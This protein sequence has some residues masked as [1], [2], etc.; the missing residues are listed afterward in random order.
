MTR[1]DKSVCVVGAG[2]VG[3]CCAIFLQRAGLQVTLIDRG[4]PGRACSYGNAGIL[5][6]TERG[7]IGLPGMF[8]SLPKWILDP[9]HPFSVRARHLPRMIPWGLAL[10][11]ASRAA[12]VERIADWMDVFFASSVERYGALL[13]S[14]GAG[15]LVRQNGYLCVYRDRRS[16]DRDAYFWDLHRRRAIRL[17]ELGG[18]E[19]RQIAPS[20]GRGFEYGLY[21]PDEGRVLD[22]YGVSRAIFDA[23]VADG[24][25]FLT[26]E[27]NQVDPSGA[28]A[29]VV[30]AGGRRSFDAVVI[31][32]GVWSKSIAR[33]LGSRVLLEAMRG[34]HA[35]L[36]SPDVEL[37]LPV[38]SG[39]HKFF[40][41]PMTHG[42]R[43]AGTAEFAGTE[44]PPK[45]TRVDTLI[46]AAKS[47]FPG[48]SADDH[49][50]WIGHRP[51]TPDSLPVVGPSPRH[52]G[53][54]F[55]FGH[56]HNGLSGA[57]MTG[58]LIADM[59]LGR[60]PEVDP[61]PFSIRRFE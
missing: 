30:S 36:P 55:A 35:M 3:L 6:A 1:Q 58:A 50:R 16:A 60:P 54:Y 21:V 31:A 29:T 32:M 34:Y 28:H 22:P 27:V 37:S 42:L 18:A 51:M 41:S 43:L 5:T 53:V 2:I 57:P 61:S 45:E 10:M 59:V 48:L 19:M 14:I 39:E 52:A 11:R 13:G 49:Q 9:L 17:H 7:P 38:L 26:D 23:F 46:D 44:A 4:E 47:L 24:G 56:G 40:A 15:D 20:L 25:V 33:Q 12:E 8:W